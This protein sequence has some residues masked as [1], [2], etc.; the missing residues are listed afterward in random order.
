MAFAAQGADAAV[1]LSHESRAVAGPGHRLADEDID[2]ERHQQEVA[3]GQRLAEAV[4]E[5][6][7]DRHLRVALA[8][9]G[10]CRS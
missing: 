9:D 7:D 3:S 8:R 5:D 10:R 1:Q 2:K 6:R 4:Q